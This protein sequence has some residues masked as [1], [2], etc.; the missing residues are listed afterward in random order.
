MAAAVQVNTG[1][2][3]YTFVALAGT[4]KVGQTVGAVLKVVNVKVL[5]PVEA[6]Q[7]FLATT[8]QVYVVLQF[9]G[10]LAETV[11]EVADVGG[12]F[13]AYSVVPVALSK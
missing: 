11:Y 5:Q 7:A 6:P 4:D 10:V 3:V 1:V 8:F 12:R 13:V 2:F 9:N